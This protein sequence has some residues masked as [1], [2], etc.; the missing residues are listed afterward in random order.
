M[1]IITLPD[2]SQRSFPQSISVQSVVENIGAGLARAALAA[3]VGDSIVDLSYVIDKDVSLSVITEKDPLGLDILRHS[4]AHLL[5]HAV[6]KLFPTAQVTIG[7][8][9]EDGFYYDF[10][11]GRPFTTED[12]ECIEAKMHELSKQNIPIHREVMTRDQA[13]HLYREL[14][15]E[16]KVRIIQDIPENQTL[17]FYRQDDF[18]DL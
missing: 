17:S 7:P 6:K 3:K 9:I 8:V 16:Y 5:A 15:E 2:G 18:I 14:G 10:A 11:F 13:V 12:L 4:T 1:P